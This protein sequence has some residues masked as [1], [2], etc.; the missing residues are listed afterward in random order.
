M[1]RQDCALFTDWIAEAKEWNICAIC[2]TADETQTSEALVFRDCGHPA[3]VGCRAWLAGNGEHR[4][5][6]C[7][8]ADL[9]CHPGDVMSALSSPPSHCPNCCGYGGPRPLVRKFILDLQQSFE[10]Q[11]TGREASSI[12]DDGASPP[13]QSGE[14]GLGGEEKAEEGGENVSEEISEGEREEESEDEEEEDMEGGSEDGDEGGGGG[15]EDGNSRGGPGG[16]GGGGA[17]GSGGNGRD[18]NEGGSKEEKGDH[19]QQ[20]GKGQRE[21]PKGGGGGRSENEALTTAPVSSG[22]AAGA[23]MNSQAGSQASGTRH[24]TKSA[25]V[26]KS[27]VSVVRTK[28]P[29]PPKPSSSP[30]EST[31]LSPGEGEAVHDEGPRLAAKVDGHAAA[32]GGGIGEMNV[33]HAPS[34]LNTKAGSSTVFSSAPKL[35]PH[36]PAVN[37]SNRS[38]E[39]GILGDAAQKAGARNSQARQAH[40]KVGARTGVRARV[41]LGPEL[42]GTSPSPKRVKRSPRGGSPTTCL[43]S[44]EVVSPARG[45]NTP[46][47][48]TVASTST[49]LSRK[50]LDSEAPVGKQPAGGVKEREVDPTLSEL[51]AWWEAIQKAANSATW[52]GDGKVPALPWEAARALESELASYGWLLQYKPGFKHF[53]RFVLM[54]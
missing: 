43:V 27:T 12:E 53:A 16:D 3:H 17:T 25:A 35:P 11:T 46:K 14:T 48:P 42:Q 41:E 18:G 45:D 5:T 8:A 30:P 52:R 20:E 22:D 9:K 7:G 44:R 50:E 37:G 51:I 40:N 21:Q 36:S 23:G 33:V 31:A 34:S 10:R 47:G 26:P 38:G 15:G 32:E 49:T 28:T 29:G 54:P 4:C 24:T 6:K 2:N 39:V 19:R 1:V 13:R